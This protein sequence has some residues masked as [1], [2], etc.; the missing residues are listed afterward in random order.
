MCQNKNS[1][2]K[3]KPV[4]RLE[5]RKRLCFFINYSIYVIIFIKLA[6]HRFTE[7]KVLYF[8]SESVCY[9]DIENSLTETHASHLQATDIFSI[10]LGIRWLKKRIAELPWTTANDLKLRCRPLYTHSLPST[11][12][13]SA[14]FASVELIRVIINSI[15]AR[16]KNSRK[17]DDGHHQNWQ[18]PPKFI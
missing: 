10:H 15:I 12:A 17:W 6:N 8:F 16:W 14:I 18:P 1:V 13:F 5:Y 2:L 9:L 3:N 7:K 4:K 11:R